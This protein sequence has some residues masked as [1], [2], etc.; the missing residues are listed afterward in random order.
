M[1]CADAAS[2]QTF[3]ERKGI[4]CVRGPSNV[5][6]KSTEIGK[7]AQPWRVSTHMRDNQGRGAL[8]Q[9]QH[10]SQSG[11]REAGAGGAK[12]SF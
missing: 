9:E 10:P 1:L 7:K 4:Y 2:K 6:K 3:W 11:M 12:T 8:E 5:L